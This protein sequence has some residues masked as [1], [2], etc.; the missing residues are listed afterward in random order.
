MFR[1]HDFTNFEKGFYIILF[2][3]MTMLK[4]HISMKTVQVNTNSILQESISWIQ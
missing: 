3:A 4:E 1:I 2:H